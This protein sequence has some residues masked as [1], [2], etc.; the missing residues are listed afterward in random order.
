M[1][2]YEGS[3]EAAMSSFDLSMVNFLQQWVLGWEENK[4]EVDFL[5]R[6]SSQGFLRKVV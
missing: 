2:F 1:T 6:D 4:M 3:D 5:D